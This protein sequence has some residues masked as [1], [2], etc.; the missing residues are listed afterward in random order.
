MGIFVLV[1]DGTNIYNALFKHL[2]HEEMLNL[3]ADNCGD[4]R[5]AFKDAEELK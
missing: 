2:R 4:K 1:I 3:E 5:C